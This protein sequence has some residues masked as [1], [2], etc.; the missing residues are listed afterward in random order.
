M[1]RQINFYMDKTTE[2]QFIRFV[3]NSGLIFLR[4][5]D[6]ITVDPYDDKD[7]FLFIIREKYLPFLKYRNNSVDVLNS[8]GIEYRRNNIIED[9]KIVTGGRLYICDVYKDEKYSTYMEDFVNDFNK[10][11]DW[12]KKHV[13][14]QNYNNMGKIKNKVYICDSMLKYSENNYRFQA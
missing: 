7:L 2:L 8:L 5:L 14:Y 1:S 10:L 9:K 4:R 13:P 6:G 12:V 11:K 3:K